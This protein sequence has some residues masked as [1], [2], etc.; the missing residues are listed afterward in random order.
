MKQLMQQEYDELV[1]DQLTKEQ[2]NNGNNK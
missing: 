1:N 2:P